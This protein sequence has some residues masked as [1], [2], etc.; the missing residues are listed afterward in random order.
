MS[1]LVAACN[2]RRPLMSIV[3]VAGQKG[4]AGKTTLA[5][6]LASEWSARGHRVQLVDADPQGTALTW[7][8]VASE[9][10]HKGPLVV[11]MGDNLRTQLATAADGFDFTVV[12]CPP[13]HGRRQA[14]A[15]AQADVAVL[16]TGPDAP[17][18]W[19]LAE[20]VDLVGDVQAMRPGLPAV[21]VINRRRPGT[22]LARR[23][24]EALADIPFPVLD[25][26][27]TLGVAFPE[28]IAA[29]LGVTEYASGSVAAGE[30]RRF[31]DEVEDVLAG[32]KHGVCSDV[33]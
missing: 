33:A 28:S 4:G 3:V 1:R 27:I 26:A 15:L 24:R 11:A 10:G 2:A 20:T 13:R 31:V 9:A 17:D 16:P 21:I 5:I 29:G 22:V 30:V 25:A 6:Q 8:A 14:W 7:S 23:A 19:A 18:V 32:R 12:D